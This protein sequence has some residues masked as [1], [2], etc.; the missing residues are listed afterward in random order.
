MKYLAKYKFRIL[1][2][3]FPLLLALGHASG[4][5]PWTLAHRLDN[6]I[7]DAR[8]RLTMP[9][10][11]DDRIVIVDIDEKSLSA[12]GRWPWSRNKLRDITTELFERQKIKTLGFDMVFAEPDNSSGLATLNHLG[13]TTLRSDAGFQAQLP[14]LNK[15][16]DYD[17]LFAES[18]DKRNV[19][20]GYYFTSDRQKHTSGKLPNPVLNKA[21]LHGHDSHITHWDG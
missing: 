19:V 15:T 20:L 17:A 9:Q 18:L 11:F 1:V 10:T 5:W 3:L 8:L 7:Y 2:S 14:F 12:L 16:Q 21:A 6:I 13:R 4:L